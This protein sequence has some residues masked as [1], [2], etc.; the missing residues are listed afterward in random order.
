MSA[1]NVAG[2]SE[3]PLTLSAKGKGHVVFRSTFDDSESESEPPATHAG[4]SRPY[5]QPFLI[6][7]MMT[8]ALPAP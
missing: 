2:R 6:E 3:V 8:D 4:H 5:D 7:D 1:V